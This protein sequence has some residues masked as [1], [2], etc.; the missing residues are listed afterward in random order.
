MPWNRAVPVLIGSFLA[1]I[2][3]AWAIADPPGY[4][5]DERAHYVKALGAGGG[6][7]Y[8]EP[9]TV[10][11][12]DLRAL[13]K[14]GQQGQATLEGLSSSAET[15]G[16]RWQRR[17]SRQFSLPAG[18]NFSAF[19]CGRW[20]SE[21][22]G[23]CIAHGHTSTKQTKTGSYVGTYQ[24][25]LYV[26]PG[27]VMRS[28]DEP[29]RALRLGRLTNAIICLGLL[30]VAALLLWDRS[31][32]ALALTGL[33]VAVTP[34]VVFFSTVLN[35]TGPEITAAICFVAALIRLTRGSGAPG[36]VWVACAASGGVLAM[37]RSLGPF[38]VAALVLTVAALAGRRDSLGAVSGARRPAL[39]AA[40]AI[41]VAA[42]AG[43]VWELHYQ[44]HVASGPAA[45][46]RGLGPSLDVLLDF[47]K[48]AVGVF[49]A[50][51]TY[52][53]LS[54]YIAWWV[55]FGAL[56]GAAAIA[57]GRRARW[58]LLALFVAVIVVTLVVAAVY[59][60]TGF[61]LQTRYVLP[62]AVVLPLWAGE[63]IN[64]HRRQLSPRAAA[65]LPLAF[66]GTAAVLHA[67]AWYANAKV[68]AAGPDA[69]WRFVSHA[70]WVPPL[71]WWT[72][73]AAAV[74]AATAY[75]LAGVAAAR[76]AA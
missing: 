8:G 33:A 30:L 19:G 42:A 46:V 23:T 7:L 36:W 35:P 71:G 4:G 37:S 26:L 20:K 15:A 9:E 56:V 38:F 57:G 21:G 60:Q 65:S 2:G 55:M 53:P 18:L 75:V 51:D 1:L 3:L 48:Q 59:R 67:I 44:P 70:D 41:A 12:A 45:I 52:L 24:P 69:G 13:F 17:T 29:L 54:L 58:S 32:G 49:G 40:G 50:L 16:A 25:Y 68:V 47:P 61:I 43:L 22:W 72:W 66:I 34:E 62:F 6:E 11:D 28:T 74:A 63:L 5:P 73:I 14:L 64:R 10:S 27:L 31:R 76:T 39:L